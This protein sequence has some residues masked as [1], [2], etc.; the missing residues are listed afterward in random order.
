MEE[1]VFSMVPGSTAPPVVLWCIVLLLGALVALFAYLACSMNS[2]RF[3]ISQQGFRIRAPLYGKTIPMA[4]LDAQKVRI[5]DLSKDQDYRPVWRNNG[6]GLQGYGMGWFTLKNNEKALI[7]LTSLS[8]VV[9]LPT[10]E[11]FSLL[12]SMEKAEEFVSEL[13]RQTG[14]NAPSNP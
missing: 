14:G 13:Q 10:T 4:A 3:V 1:K 11:G 12:M 9:Y 5:L 8:T 7:F 2:V 6:L